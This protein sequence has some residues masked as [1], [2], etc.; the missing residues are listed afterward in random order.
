VALYQWF[1]W[2]PETKEGMDLLIDNSFFVGISIYAL[3]PRAYRYKNVLIARL[4]FMG[5]LLSALVPMNLLLF[6]KIIPESIP[7]LNGPYWSVL[8]FVVIFYIKIF[9]DA[10]DQQ[11]KIRRP[12]EEIKA[13]FC[14]PKCGHQN[15]IG[16]H[17]CGKCGEKLKDQL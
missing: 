12:I 6:F 2:F 17:F 7:L 4:I 14:C 3:G 8:I 10:V 9:M 15:R 5:I 1:E 13:L 11:Y 16:K